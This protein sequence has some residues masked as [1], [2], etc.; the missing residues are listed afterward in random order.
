MRLTYLRRGAAYLEDKEIM[1]FL[2]SVSRTIAIA[3]DRDRDAKQ[4]SFFADHDNLTGLLNRT[5]L[6]RKLSSAIKAASTDASPMAIARTN[7]LQR[8][9]PLRRSLLGRVRRSD[10]IS[11]A[12]HWMSCRDFPNR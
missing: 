12:V 4:I 1:E 5:A 11:A 8:S 7:S 9:G 2:A 6:D 3:I 10:S